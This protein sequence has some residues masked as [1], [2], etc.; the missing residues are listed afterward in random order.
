MDRSGPR[1]PQGRNVT[2]NTVSKDGKQRESGGQRRPSREGCQTKS[3]TRQSYNAKSMR[4]G[5]ERGRCRESEKKV[6]TTLKGGG[7]P[8]PD[9]SAPSGLARVC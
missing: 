6:Q 4:R 7:H 3:K 8:A 1:S 5:E 2:Q 9:A